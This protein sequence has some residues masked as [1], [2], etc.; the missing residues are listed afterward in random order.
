GWTQINGRNAT[1]WPT[2]FALDLWYVDHWTNLLDLHILLRTIPAV[3]AMRDIDPKD[4]ATMDE[5]MGET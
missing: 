1:T 4:R 3:L 5:F 2:R